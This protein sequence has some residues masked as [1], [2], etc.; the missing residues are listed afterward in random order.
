MK[1]VAIFGMVLVGCLVLCF[2]QYPSRS[3]RTR[4]KVVQLPEPK[5][6][7]SVSLEEALA[8]RR[9]VR[10]FSGEP[11][12]YAQLG[13]LAWA[14]QGITERERGLRTAP[15]AGETYPIELYFGVREG[16]FVYRPQSHTFEQTSEQDI[17]P[18]LAE[19]AGRQEAAA[20]AAC[21]IILAGSVKK[22]SLRFRNDARKYMLLEAGH[23]AQNIQLQAVCLDLG[24]VTIGGFD[25]MG[26]RRAC[27]LAK[28]LEPIYVICVG[29]PVGQA[30]PPNGTE[31]A[32]RAADQARA[33][34]AVLIAAK[35]GF[36]DEE[37]FGTM[38]ALANARV[39]TAVASS[40]TGPIRGSLG[41]MTEA[42][43]L[44]GAI[45]VDE[46][47]AVIFVGG[48]GATEYFGDPVA[49]GVAREAV[50]KGKV[51]AAISIAPT[52]LANAGVLNGVRTTSFLSERE[53]LQ[54][55]GA[56]YTGVPVERDRLIITASSPMATAQFGIAIAD[57]LAGR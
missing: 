12:K 57:A 4:L 35:E 53:R 47:D 33:K 13:Q 41:G 36:H 32:A 9:S 23:I 46:C 39:Q 18:M 43:M 54:R 27:R 1:R 20:T 40:I 37:L 16:A 56:V 25:I 26:V 51:V 30:A 19:A 3:A 10:Q 52:I 21:D 14:G 5:L 24:S 38:R 45:N 2:G 49:L 34:K 11:L 48:P 29:Y 6:T 7:G 22:L 50:N 42:T 28:E 8:R 55:A 15:S 17:R 31:E 44:V